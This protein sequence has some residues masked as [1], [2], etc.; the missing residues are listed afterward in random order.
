MKGGAS[1]ES[2][3]HY[4]YN[5]VLNLKGERIQVSKNTVF[6]INERESYE[7]DIY[8]EF[9]HVGV[10]HRVAI[11]CKD[12]KKPVDQ[13][14][15]LLFHQKI[16][17]VGDEV[18]GVFVSRKGYQ[19][20]AIDVGRRHGILMLTEQDIPTLGQLVGKRITAA[21]IPEDNCMGEPFWYIAELDQ[22]DQAPNG[23]FYAFPEPHPV[24]LPLFFS[25]RHA[26]A[27][28]AKLSRKEELKVFGMPQYKLR[29]FLAAALLRNMAIGLVID[30]PEGDGKLCMYPTDAENINRDFLLDP[31]VRPPEPKGLSKWIERMRPRRH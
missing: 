3:V 11:E 29:G 12:W 23:N 28:L 20:G 4:V 30:A 22:S 15:V 10:R 19:S 26:E 14:Q 8:Y 24:K 2:Y 25:R 1:F 6:R 21:F 31:I 9:N 18:V 16:K 27:Y 5:S 17:N 13:G 7:I